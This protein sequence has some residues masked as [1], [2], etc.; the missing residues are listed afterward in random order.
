MIEDSEIEN[1]IKKLKENFVKSKKFKIKKIKDDRIW[2]QKLKTYFRNIIFDINRDLKYIQRARLLLKELE[3]KNNIKKLS[4]TKRSS[5]EEK[6]KKIYKGIISLKSSNILKKV[7]YKINQMKT[8]SKELQKFNGKSFKNISLQFYR[9]N[10]PRSASDPVEKLKKKMRPKSTTTYCESRINKLSKSKIFDTSKNDEFSINKVNDEQKLMDL[11]FINLDNIYKK[12]NKKTINIGRINDIYRFQLN[13]NFGIFS[14]L[15]HLEDIKHIQLDDINVRKEIQDIDKQIDE[16]INQKSQ[17]LYF[18]KEYEKYILKNKKILSKSKSMINNFNKN[19]K[20]KIS[21]FK[22]RANYSSK[23]LYNPKIGNIFK[24]NLNLDKIKKMS[25]KEKIN[26]KGESLR[27]L[28]EKLGETLQ[29]E[30]IH[31]FINDRSK[32][33]RTKSI[34]K[35]FFELQKK[36]F[37]KLIE[38]EQ[39]INK[40]IGEEKEKE[41]ND[42]IEK[43]IIKLEDILSKDFAHNNLLN[44]YVS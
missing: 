4:E 12:I 30:H 14:P 17:G 44:N 11:R 31:K 21:S 7:Y 2:T 33:K 42:K 37:P 38:L 39:S 13:K 27:D 32:T 29:V 19:N 40:E 6:P 3:E 22:L 35:D 1:K 18:K 5:I 34:K 26:K 41:T 43:Y 16:K 28:T 8:R 10:R 25:K 23:N 15:K 36:Y 9:T 20:K 24:E